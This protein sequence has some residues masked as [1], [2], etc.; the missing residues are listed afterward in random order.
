MKP[1]KNEQLIAI[2]SSDGFIKTINLNSLE[3]LMGQKR[4]NLPVTAIGFID[5]TDFNSNELEATP[6]HV[7][8]GSA[9][10][11]YNII[12]LPKKSSLASIFGGIWSL[13]WHFILLLAIIFY[14]ALYLPVN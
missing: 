4:H 8:T 10:Y 11:L 7:V 13:I 3:V 2:A 6:N 1:S 12:K 14:F 5:S 9:D